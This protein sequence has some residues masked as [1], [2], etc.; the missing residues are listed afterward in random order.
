MKKPIKLATIEDDNNWQY[1]IKRIVEKDKIFKISLVCKCGDDFFDKYNLLHPVDFVLL[2]INLPCTPGLDVAGR[3]QKQFPKLPIVVFTSSKNSSDRK[4]FE[5]IGVNYF[6]S[7]MRSIKLQE[8]LKT[9]FGLNNSK[10][11]RRL[12]PIHDDHYKFIELVC[13]GKTNKEI[14]DI[15]KISLK[16]VEYKQKTICDYYQLQNSKLAIVDFA[17]SYDILC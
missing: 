5:Y 11:I 15:F 16:N 10:F 9:I 8:D 12:M 6:I 7:K 14:A 2:D 17:R 3:I 1:L 4:F 13:K